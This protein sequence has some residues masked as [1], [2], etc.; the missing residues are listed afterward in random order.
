MTTTAKLVLVNG[1]VQ[2]F[3][4]LWNDPAGQTT[5]TALNLTA[6][7][8]SVQVSDGQGCFDNGSITVPEGDSVLVSI[9]RKRY[10]LQW[11]N[12]GQAVANVNGGTSPLSISVVQWR[13]L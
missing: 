9:V 1:G 5:D 7:T 3:T 10:Y 8:Y 2:P 6:G 13:G 12:D 4:F 11:S